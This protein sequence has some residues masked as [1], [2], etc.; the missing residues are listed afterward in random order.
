RG[1]ILPAM[2]PTPIPDWLLPSIVLTPALLWMFLGVG[3]PWALAILPRSHWRDRITII[4][5]AMALGPALTTAAMFLIGT[6]GHFTVAN[7]LGSSALI[8]GIGLALAT[9]NRAVY[10]AKPAPK[11]PYTWID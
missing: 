5:V 8:A 11:R 2:N 9:R 10:P 4:A 6:F 3:I 1:S 7:V